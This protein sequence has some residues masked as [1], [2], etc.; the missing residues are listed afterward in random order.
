MTPGDLGSLQEAAQSLETD[1]YIGFKL[2]DNEDG[3]DE[4]TPYPLTLR[5]TSAPPQ[6][7]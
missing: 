2:G 5:G 3:D 1:D 7:N 6:D 4:E